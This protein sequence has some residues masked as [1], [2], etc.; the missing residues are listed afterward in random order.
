MLKSYASY[1]VSYL[2][3][4]MKNMDNIEKVILFGSVARGE[5]TKN[6]DVDLFIDVK[7][8]NKRYE[9]EI[10]RIEEKFYQSRENSIFRSKEINNKLNIKIGRLSDWKD[11]Q[12]S[13]AS[14]GIIFYGNYQSKTLPSDVNHYVIIF[15]SKIGINRGAFLNKLY[16][17]RMNE[18]YYPGMVSS[19]N[20]KKLGKSC[21]MIPIQYKNDI[22]KLLK[23]YK[24]EA[25]NLEVFS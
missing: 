11:I 23:D 13:I 4:N 2:L 24:V 10:R 25:K 12:K 21:I 19:F 1:F 7:K 9:E 16:G 18:K 15:W 5:S 6:S 3:S 22:F 17:V 8:K 14:T 20:G